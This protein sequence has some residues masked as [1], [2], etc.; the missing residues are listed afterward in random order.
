MEVDEGWISVLYIHVRIYIRLIYKKKAPNVV[1]RFTKCNQDIQL[2]LYLSY[3][4]NTTR[5]PLHPSYILF[6]QTMLNKPISP[7]APCFPNL[8]L[9]PY[10]PLIPLIPK[11][12]LSPC[13][14][15][16]P[17]L[18]LFPFFLSFLF[19]PPF[20]PFPFPFLSFPFPFI[21][22]SLFPLSFLFFLF[23]LPFLFFFSLLSLSIP[24]FP[25][26]SPV[27]FLFFT[28]SFFL[29]I[30]LLFFYEFNK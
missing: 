15:P 25:G 12:H 24:S 22:S 16:L 28:L 17:L 11:Y 5:N 2:L 18:F 6:S 9:A 26:S 27:F 29:S 30:Y 20:F 7:Q 14:S 23:L 8:T 1:V 10:Q 19:S 13:L 4:I 3:S 21:F